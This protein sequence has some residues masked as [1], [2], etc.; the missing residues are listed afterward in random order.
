[1]SI[2][3]NI[4]NRN[5]LKSKAST[6][7]VGAVVFV[8]SLILL[9]ATSLTNGIGAQMINSY[10]NIQ[11]ADIVVLWENID[12]VSPM[13]PSKL[14]GTVQETFESDKDSENQEAIAKFNQY[15]EENE[16]KYSAMYKNIHR[17]A[18]VC[19]NTIEK[20]ALTVYSLDEKN[21][22]HLIDTKTIKM[23]SGDL[24]TSGACVAISEGNAESLGVEIGEKLKLEVM[25]IGG[26]TVERE[27]EVTGIYAN[28]AGYDNTNI[29]MSEDEAHNLYQME[30]EYFDIIRLYTKKGNLNTLVD[31]ISNS[32][33]GDKSTLRASTYSKCCTLY[34]NIE[35]IIKLVFYIFEGFLLII[36]AM[37]IRSNVRLNL[38]A[39]SVEF[40]TIRAMG[41]SKR[42]CILITILEIAVVSLYA[43]IVAGIVV[44]VACKGISTN[45]IY[46]GTGAITYVFGG[47][48]FYP[49]VKIY[50]LI[51]GLIIFLCFSVI[52]TIGPGRKMHKHKI[53]DLLNKS[54]K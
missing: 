22:D 54:V 31:E 53:I 20:K 33:G 47:E 21:A 49:F 9:A 13:D 10:K 38:M 28:G 4:V 3:L 24:L 30:D 26:E 7:L 11:A 25:T 43:Y 5:I 41:Y 14:L 46:V 8:L 35:L 1:M 32:L 52:S 44:F 45:G 50:D 23:E 2:I 48:R 18:S 29:Y 27:Y 34:P 19:G 12:E 36:I 51:G 15:Y 39:R 37:G 6:I 16:G 40:G 42:N 17:S